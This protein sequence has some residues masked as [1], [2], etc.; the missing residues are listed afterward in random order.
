MVEIRLH[1]LGGQGAVTLI[2][3]LAIAGD[4][5][6]K[7]VQA[8]PFFGAER[9]GSPVKSFARFDDRKID[10]RSQIYKPDF[11]VVM[12]RSLMSAAIDD[13]VKRETTILINERH[14]DAMGKYSDISHRILSVDATSIALAMK[15]EIEGM[16]LVNVPIFGAISYATDLVPLESV[17]EVIRE[18]ISERNQEASIEAAR[19]GFTS[20]QE[21][22]EYTA[23]RK[24]K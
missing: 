22:N 8:Y 23:T 6:G 3:M 17:V 21:V 13:G 11:L 20:V 12:N 19:R 2:R 7:E 5:L 10:V 24:R 14:E 1:S 4:K 18:T 15:L 16:P 9:R